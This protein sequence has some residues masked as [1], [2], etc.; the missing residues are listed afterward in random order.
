[1]MIHSLLKKALGL[2]INHHDKPKLSEIKLTKAAQFF[3]V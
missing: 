2:L 3:N 1:M